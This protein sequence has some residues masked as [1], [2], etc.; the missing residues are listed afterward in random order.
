MSLRNLHC[1]SRVIGGPGKAYPKGRSAERRGQQGYYPGKCASE[2]VSLS[3]RLAF[4]P[5]LA[6]HLVSFHGLAY[7]HTI[8]NINIKKKNYN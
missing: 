2:A 5:I 3:P 4:S 7:L 6:S 1:S 8:Y